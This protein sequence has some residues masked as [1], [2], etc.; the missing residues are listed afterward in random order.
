MSARLPD[1]M[2]GS[3][4]SEVCLK[5][6]VY[7]CGSLGF[8]VA[9]ALSKLATVKAVRVIYGPYVRQRRSLQTK[10][11]LIVRHEGASG[12]AR[13]AASRAMSLVRR[14]GS[15]TDDLTVSRSAALAAG[16]TATWVQDLNGIEAE[17]ATREFGA[18]LGIVAGTYILK[19][20]TFDAP[21]LGSIN[22]H[23]GKTPEYRGGPPLFWELYNG[24][25]EFGITIH[26]VSAKLDAGP[27]ILEQ[28]FPLA[29]PAGVDPMQYISELNAKVV[30]PSGISMLVAAADDILAGRANER[31]QTRSDL[32]PNRFPSHNAVSILKRRARL[33]DQTVAPVLCEASAVKFPVK[34]TIKSLLG[35]VAMSSGQSQR[36][37]GD[38]G[39]CVLFHRVD[40]RLKENAISCGTD[41]FRQYCRFFKTNFDVIDLD[42]AVRRVQTG[43]SLKGTAVITFDDGYLDNVK[44]AAPILRE[45]GL[46]A[47]FYIATDFIGSQHV[48]WWDK[49][50]PFAPEWMS[51][52]D[53]RSL[54][55]QGFTIGAHTVTHVDLGKVDLETAE[56]EIRESK[57]RLER[58]L[59]E[60][61]EHF[62]FPYG[63]RDNI[64]PETLDLVKR[65]GFVSCVSAYGGFLSHDDEPFGLEREPISPWYSTPYHFGFEMLKF[66][67]FGRSA[68]AYGAVQPAS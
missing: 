33:Q 36:L 64:R 50:L 41:S 55:R 34:K 62:S 53:V 17:T 52:D 68:G 43:A 23:S 2:R 65:A 28:I 63:R 38:R 6:V 5:V 18:D 66:A 59:G 67:A 49:E 57:I 11:R 20:R 4:A 40:D 15:S 3:A 39:L 8:D 13:R 30:R 31:P 29:R 21:R 1:F 10:L 44:T 26:K 60:P 35:H 9:V 32:P 16:V 37:L 19:P 12:L 56:R 54:R 42:E 25:T 24:E 47:T 27:I 14:Q 7:T 46:P 48:P 51:W 45:L 22:L 58:E 61:I